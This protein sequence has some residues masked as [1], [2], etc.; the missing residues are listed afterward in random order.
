MGGVSAGLLCTGAAGVV[1]TVGVT[2]DVDQ[3]EGPLRATTAG[4]RLVAA[5][6]GMAGRAP[7]RREG[8]LASGSLE[9]RPGEVREAH[10][11]APAGRRAGVLADP[12]RPAARAGRR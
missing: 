8:H 9:E 2:N 10:R 11:S 5:Y 1:V 7:A 4:H 12:R 6:R 3:A